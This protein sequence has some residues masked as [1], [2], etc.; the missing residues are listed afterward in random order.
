LSDA[1]A[2]FGEYG[3]IV[4]RPTDRRAKAQDSDLPSSSTRASYP[5]DLLVERQELIARRTNAGENTQVTA[6]IAH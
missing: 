4:T 3:A 5:V 6:K 2:Q 1:L